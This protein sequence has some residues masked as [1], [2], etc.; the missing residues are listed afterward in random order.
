MLATLHSPA[1]I[2]Q[3]EQLLRPFAYNLTRSQE[4]TEDLVQDTF[5]KALLNQDKFN[6][7]TNIKGWLFTIMRNIFINSYHKKRR[8]IKVNDSSDNLYLINSTATVE[9]NG[10]ERIFL[11][12]YI[13]S[14]IADISPDFTK[15]FMMYYSGFRYTEIAEKLGLPLGTVK[16]RIFFA[17]KGI[18][19][20]LEKM[21]IT[22]SSFY[23]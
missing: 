3:Y 5:Y 16:S 15:P 10:S 6:E 12:E 1:D 22:N 8:N 2:L 20:S 13:R 4:E 17:R 11:D 23:N 19:A 7:G 18:Q 9:R 21:G 14:A